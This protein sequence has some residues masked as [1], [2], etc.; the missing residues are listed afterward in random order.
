VNYD[1]RPSMNVVAEDSVLNDPW[2]SLTTDRA[3]GHFRSATQMDPGRGSTLLTEER[4]DE[5]TRI[6]RDLH[7]TLL[8]GFQGVSLLVQSAVDG[9]PT[10]SPNKASLMRALS[11]MRRVIDEGRD[12]LQGLRSSRTPATKLEQALAEFGGQLAADSARF[13]LT[14]SGRSR[15]L[16]ETVQQQLFLIVRE[17]LVNALRHSQATRIEADVEYLAGK[18][19]VTVRDDG[20]GIDQ[21]VLESGRTSHWGLLGMRERARNIGAQLRIW[22]RKDAGTEVEISVPERHCTEHAYSETHPEID[23]MEFKPSE[24]VAV[25]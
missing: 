12:T 7:D 23:D 25:A 19:R 13:H 21:Q 2:L 9:M 11:L 18:M 14:V 20:C 5:R 8:Q 6:A 24:A 10:D 3:A 17:A 22:S 1:L 15:V 4:Q 16:G